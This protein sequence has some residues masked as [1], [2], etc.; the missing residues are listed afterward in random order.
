MSPFLTTV[1]PAQT[2]Y[3]AQKD[4]SDQLERWLYYRGMRACFENPDWGKTHGVAG[5]DDQDG[6][7]KKDEINKGEVWSSNPVYRNSKEGFGYIGPSLDGANDNDGRV[8]CSDADIW[9]NGSKAF[10]FPDVMSLIC[11]MDDAMDLL[12]KGSK[13]EPSDPTNCTNS[14]KIT[15]KGVEDS[16]SIWQQALTKALENPSASKYGGDGDRPSFKFSENEGPG[17]THKSLWYLMGK[18]SLEVFCGGGASIESASVDND[19]Y[20]NSNKAVSV[21]VVQTDG[22][23]KRS[24]SYPLDSGRTEGSR[25]K[26]VYYADSDNDNEASDRTCSDMARWTR[27]GAKDYASY[28]S[29]LI[30]NGETPPG[31]GTTTTSDSSDEKEGTTCGIDGIGWIVCPVMTFMAKLNDGAFGFLNNFL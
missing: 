7:R 4:P 8:N 19:V 18:K 20:K 17:Y 26:D 12:G 13:I 1:F 16:G 21:F 5:V 3:A 28:I 6:S 30:A 29:S 23:I 2:A 24:Q 14:S 10:G 15:F 22:T 31:T 9:K 11:A 27:E 25:V